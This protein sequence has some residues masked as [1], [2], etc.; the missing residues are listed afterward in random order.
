[1]IHLSLLNPADTIKKSSVAL[2]QRAFINSYAILIMLSGFLACNID[3][4]AKSDPSTDTQ[5]IAGTSKS[6]ENK[7]IT[8]N[9][10]E[11]THE[12][13]GGSTPQQAKQKSHQSITV[14][15]KKIHLTKA[16]YVQQDSQC[17]DH[18]LKIDVEFKLLNKSV[19]E[20]K[21]E[22]LEFPKG[23]VTTLLYKGKKIAKFLDYF[24]RT[25]PRWDIHQ[26]DS[27]T[28]R[29]NFTASHFF[30]STLKI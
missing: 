11:L 18:E 13:P 24:E 27:K 28:G 19:Q 9:N 30:S 3:N 17:F 20:S 1:M 14:A 2:S 23:T 7:H 12:K 26:M 4:P 10:Y 8:E 15:L 29:C 5:P 16:L 25:L 21:K 6:A 22:K